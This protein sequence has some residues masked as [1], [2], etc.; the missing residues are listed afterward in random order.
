VIGPAGCRDLG[1]LVARADAAMY[2]AKRDRTRIELWHAALAT[3]AIDLGLDTDL[4]AAIRDGELVLHYQPLV[5]ART[6]VTASVEALVRWSHPRRGLLPPQA[7]LPAAA[8]TPLEVEVDLWVLRAVA[9]QRARWRAAGR[10]LPL[11]L[12][13]GPSTLALADLAD[14][15]ACLLLE[16]DLPAGAPV[17]LEL[18][19]AETVVQDDVATAARALKACA[20]HGIGFALDDFGTGYASLATLRRL[21]VRTLKIERGFIERMLHDE[22]ELHMVRAAVGMAQAFGARAVAV[23]VETEAQAQLLAELGCEELQGFGI[24]PPMSAQE[25]DLWLDGRVQ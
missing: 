1:D 9:A 22:G 10:Q 11:S 21:P 4:R 3:G 23:G 16:E 8:G 5:D 24:A 25:L 12:N 18:E 14:T 19:V 13:I 7:F 20:R 2:A 6:R 17:G 15:V